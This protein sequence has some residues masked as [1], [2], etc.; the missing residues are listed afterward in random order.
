MLFAELALPAQVLEGSLEPFG[1]VLKH[2]AKRA[3]SIL[4]YCTGANRRPQLRKG[5]SNARDL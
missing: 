3:P 5:G 2:R 1:Q 4:I